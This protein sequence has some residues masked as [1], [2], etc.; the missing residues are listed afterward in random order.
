MHRVNCTD[1][2]YAGHE[3]LQRLPQD[4]VFSQRLVYR[5]AA[6]VS[7]YTTQSRWSHYFQF[8]FHDDCIDSLPIQ[9]C[10]QGISLHS[11]SE[12]YT[13][14]TRLNCRVASRRRCEQNSQ[15][16]HDD[17]RRI[18]STIIWKL[19]RLHSG[20]T[21]WSLIDIDEFFNNDVDH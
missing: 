13:P 12:Q 9:D 3:L 14:P 4:A 2:M 1:C 6:V 7:A 20:L 21:T 11:E 17:S 18:R 19:T 10:S 16:A 8:R 5:E 15:L